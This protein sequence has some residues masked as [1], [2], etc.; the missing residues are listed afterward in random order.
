MPERMTFDVG[1][2]RPRR[3][4]DGDEPMR[5][6]V[7]GDF[8][9]D[10]VAER[11]PL[12]D[13]PTLRLDVDSLET[14]MRRLRPALTVPAGEIRFHDIDDFHPD[15]LYARLD[16]FKALRE[17]R[18][19]PPGADEDVDRLLGKVSEP[20][21]TTPVGDGA[22]A[23]AGGLDALIREAIAPH[24]VKDTSAQTQAYVAA[25]DSAI[26]EQM[27]SLLHHAAFQ[28]LEATWRGVHWLVSRLELDENLQL[29]LFDV[30]RTELLTD[31][32]DAKGEISKT[33]LYRALVDRW[34]NV[35][36]AQGWSAFITLTRFGP[37]SA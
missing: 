12:A 11:P 19:N 25:V 6:L 26:A 4:R 2:G 29:H 14:V 34:R 20:R 27:R 36:G 8:R 28:S 17:K 13:R 18:A 15:R 21:A 9:G 5:L 22:P 16:V 23:V 24:I 10:A 35:P 7:L 1:F 30:S 3:R 37:S 33:G 31:I 32:A